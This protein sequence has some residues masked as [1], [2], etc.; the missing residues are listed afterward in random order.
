[1]TDGNRTTDPASLPMDVKRKLLAARDALAEGDAMEAYHRI[2][3]IACPDFAKHIDEVWTAL[4]TPAPE[5]SPGARVEDVCPDCGTDCERCN[6]NP[7]PCCPDCKCRWRERPNGT[8]PSSRRQENG[9]APEPGAGQNSYQR[10]FEASCVALGE[11]AKEA[12]V[13]EEHADDGPEAILDAIRELK[14]R[15][16]SGEPS[17]KLVCIAGCERPICS[18][19]QKQDDGEGRVDTYCAACGHSSECHEP[20]SPGEPGGKWQPIETA[21]RDGTWIVGAHT[22]GFPPFVARYSQVDRGWLDSERAYRDPRHW[23]PIPC[24]TL[25]KEAK[26]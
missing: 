5:S 23:L 3:S 16:S 19:F 18:N 21:P 11:I 6:A 4:E 22:A 25:T 26:P 9:H 24:T 13:P 14:R 1:M 8:D 17:A 15:A 20:V 2:Y 10:M 12:G 7:R